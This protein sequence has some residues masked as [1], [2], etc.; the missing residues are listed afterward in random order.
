MPAA[1]EAAKQGGLRARSGGLAVQS[2][3]RSDWQRLGLPAH[4]CGLLMCLALWALAPSSHAQTAEPVERSSTWDTVTF[5]TAL[6]AAGVELLMPR[7]ADT[8][9][10]RTLGW[11]ARHHVSVLVPALALGGLAALNEF[12]LRPDVF[13]SP[14]P[15]CDKNG[16][17]DCFGLFSTHTVGSFAALGHGAAVFFVDTVSSGNGKVSYGSL[18]GHVGIPFVFSTVTAVGR[19][20]GNWES[21]GQ[22][23]ASA[24]TGLG[25]GL[26]VGF[27]YATLQPPECGYSGAL[28]CW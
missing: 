8:L 2:R 5:V 11:K 7:V 14:R 15:G 22:I 6:S 12:W 3:P 23:F 16:G 25:L 27:A 1:V 4:W 20:V 28:I 21:T 19:G 24:G 17:A 26:L 18:I 9:P 10:E 13:E